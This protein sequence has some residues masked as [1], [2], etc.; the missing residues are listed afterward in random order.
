MLWGIDPLLDADLLFALRRMGHGDEIAIVDANFP[1]A[2]TATSTVTGAPI[3]MA[4]VS[5]ARAV[6]AVLSVMPLDSFVP[7]PAL[8]MEVVDDPVAVPPVQQE[9]QQAIDRAAGRRVPL[10]GIERFAFYDR[11]GEAFAIL[12]TGERRHYGCFIFKKGVLPP[13]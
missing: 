3:L 10:V 13:E 9:V 2:S 4:G 7:D 11:A 1:A 5:S 12:V 6:E 8:R